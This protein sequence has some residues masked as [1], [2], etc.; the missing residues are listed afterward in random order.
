[1]VYP[2]ECVTDANFW[3]DLHAGGLLDEAFRLPCQWVIPDVVLGELEQPAGGV[4]LR[5]G[6]REVE[7]SGEQ[8]AE[9]LELASRY[10][11][12][13][14]KDLFA[15]A[16]AKTSGATL[17]TGD[18]NL[19]TAAEQEGLDVHGTLWVLDE[20]VKRKIIKPQRAAGALE[21]MVRHGR[22]L[23]REGVEYRVQRWRRATS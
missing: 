23:P 7:L 18:R 8:V 3:I 21:R 16:F 19:R 1:M 17:I 5:H 6:L 2:S 15:L 12:P 4:L 14:R 20:M 13:S 9:V 10:P 11:K 22:R